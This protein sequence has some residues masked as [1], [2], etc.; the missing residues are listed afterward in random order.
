MPILCDITSP[1]NILS[2][3]VSLPIFQEQP[4]IPFPP[5][6]SPSSQKALNIEMILRMIILM[7]VCRVNLG[8][9][10]R[11]PGSRKTS[12]LVIIKIQT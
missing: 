9:T 11:E 3:L 2:L 7:M 10:W 6:L 5:R 12:W 8:L 1:Y 4:E